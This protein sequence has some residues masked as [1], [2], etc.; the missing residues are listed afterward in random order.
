[1]AESGKIEFKLLDHKCVE[2][3]TVIFNLEDGAIV[4]VKVDLDRVGVATNFK[5]PDGTPRYV[6]NASLK[7]KVIPANKK[8]SL[9]K[10]KLMTPSKSQI[11]PPNHIA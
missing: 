8:F 7:I 11:V 9:P 4:K 6:V 1:M 10:S 3:D 2:S 5:N